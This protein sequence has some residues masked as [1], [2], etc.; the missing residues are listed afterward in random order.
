[1]D[2]AEPLAY[3]KGIKPEEFE[4]LQPGELY[5]WLEACSRRQE[6]NDYKAAYFTAWLLSPYGKVD[7]RKIADP[8]WKGKEAVRE[9]DSRELLEERKKLIEEFGLKEGEING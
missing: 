9:R 3:E 4:K 2:F 8:L 5:K 7:Y 1:M 6:A